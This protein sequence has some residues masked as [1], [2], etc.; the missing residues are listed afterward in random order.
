RGVCCRYRPC[1]AE[2]PVL[3]AGAR[4][5]ALARMGGPRARACRGGGG[6]HRHVD[7]GRPAAAARRRG[8]GWGA[9]DRAAPAAHHAS[10]RGHGL[11]HAR[12]RLVTF[13][14]ARATMASTPSTPILS[15]PPE[16]WYKR[17]VWPEPRYIALIVAGVIVIG[18]GAAYGISHLV[19]DNGSPAGKATANTQQSANGGAPPTTAKKKT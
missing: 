14:K 12:A 11:G 8:H 7:R 5:Q 3:L 10:R 6:A 15:R 19:N 4:R 16:P 9:H 13:A 2:R 18:G 1:C 17:V